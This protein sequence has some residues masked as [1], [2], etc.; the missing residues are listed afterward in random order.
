MFLTKKG[1]IIH[2]QKRVKNHLNLIKKQALKE[3][4]RIVN[5]DDLLLEHQDSENLEIFG[6]AMRN[7]LLKELKIYNCEQV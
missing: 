5:E 6:A 7:V 2:N 1:L 3:V 4:E